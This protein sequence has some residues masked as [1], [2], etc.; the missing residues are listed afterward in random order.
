MRKYAMNVYFGE[1]LKKHADKAAEQKA[2][3]MGIPFVR[4]LSEIPDLER[5][6]E[7]VSI[8]GYKL[9]VACS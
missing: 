5:D 8:D 1:E 6:F 9:L 3:K 2:K 7:L 4:C